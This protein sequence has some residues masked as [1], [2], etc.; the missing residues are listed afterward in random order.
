MYLDSTYP[1]AVFCIIAT[2]FCERFSF[3]GLRTI[4]SLYLRNVLEFSEDASTVIYH[5]FIMA[6]YVLPVVGAI[7]ADSYSGRY[8]TIRNFSLIYLAGNTLMCIAAVP[9]LDHNPILLSFLALFLIA[10]GTGGL[11]PCVAA[12][13]AEQFQLPEQKELLRYFFSVFY[14]TINLGGFVGMIV[15]PIVRKAVSCF[16][17]DTC[18]LLG[19]GFPAVLM[20]LSIL[21]FVLGKNFY[22]LKTP[23]KNVILEFIKCSS[24]ALGQKRKLSKRIRQEHWLDYAKSNFE[25]KLIKDMKIVFA[26]L[27][28]FVPLPIFWSLFD[29]QGSRWTFQASHMDASVLGIQIVPDQMQVINPAMVLVLIPVFD[30]GFYPYCEKKNILKNPLHRMALGGMAAGLSFISGILELVLETTYP[31]V[32]QR[33]RISVNVINTMPCDVTIWNSLDKERNLESGNSIRFRNILKHNKTSYKL[34]VNAPKNCGNISLTNKNIQ[35]QKT[36]EE[37]QE[38]TFIISYDEIKQIRSY[39]TDPID[40]TKSIS[41]IPKIR[42]DYVKNTNLLQNITVTFRSSSGLEDMYFLGTENQDFGV[43]ASPYMEIPQGVYECVISSGNN[44]RD[45]EKHFHLAFGGVYSLIITE[46]HGKVEFVKLFTTSAPNS[47]NILWQLPQYF[48]ISIAEIMFGVAGLEFSFTQ[49]PKSLK[50]VTIAGWYLSTAA[51]NLIVIVIAH[52]FKRQAY[53]F[54]LFAVVIVADMVIFTEMA[55]G[56]HF[57]E[58]EVDSSVLIVNQSKIEEEDH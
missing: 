57:V 21:L 25:M 48:L 43:I 51:G 31:D 58:L 7:C 22:K 3:C 46:N 13:G 17:D 27:L 54:F 36:L 55:S 5:I 12:F 14:F 37:S 33:N 23:K 53:E 15:T 56:Y 8:R 19:F 52:V 2:E 26:I 28:L 4:L 30:K 9:V 11:K 6:C 35:V 38:D 44:N 47:I 49:A 45:Y 42:I 34:S 1:T 40:S 41:G 24:Y 50:T 39:L 18:Y 29:Q 10:V 20:L 16:G 32:P